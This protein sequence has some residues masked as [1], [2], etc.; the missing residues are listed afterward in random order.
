MRACLLLVLV[1]VLASPA[2]AHADPPDRARTQAAMADYFDGEQRGGYVLM[3]LGVAGMIAGGWL[4]RTGTPTARGASYPLLGVGVIH[5]AAGIFVNV[6][7]ARRVETFTTQ[8]EDDP[9]A[10]VAAERVRMQ[11]VSKQLTA[12]E[13]AEVVLIA[14]G[15]TA[16]AVGWRTDRP[17]WKGAGL[18]LA[19]EAACTLGFDVAAARRA[20]TYR[21]A[22]DHTSVVAGI[23]PDTGATVTTLTYGGRF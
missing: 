12:L 21:V 1:T 23:D 5:L 11:G 15:L 22:L 19:L 14:G 10:F 13:I 17:G 18:T 6:A 20:K 3:G 7:S 8:I 4:Y 2:L 16:A 9:A